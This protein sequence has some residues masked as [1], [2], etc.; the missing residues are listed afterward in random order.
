M[1]HAT[2]RDG[3]PLHYVLEGD[4]GPLVVLVQGLGLSGAFWGDVPQTLLESTPR[5]RVLRVDNRGV[6]GTGRPWRP[7]SIADMAD[8]VACVLDAVGAQT[9]YL[10]GISMGGMIAQEFALRHPGRLDGLVLMAT[11][12]GLPHGVPP[13]P[14]S[15]ALLA[16]VPFASIPEGRQRIF[17]QLFFGTHAPEESRRR[18][19]AM[20]SRWRPLLEAER[21]SPRTFLWQLSAAARHSAGRRLA[22]IRCPV[23]VVAGADDV[24][25]LP[26]NSKRLAQL[27]PHATLE[28]VEKAGHALP[29]DAPRVVRDSI[30]RVRAAR[31]TPRKAS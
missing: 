24:L 30:D 8:D 26:E 31:E 1:P 18:A 6:G 2:A 9:A 5:H 10:A 20:M 13:P 29:A 19:E 21:R 12:P 22:A 27:I 7:W 25:I 11:T 3:T 15:L 16:R 14:S 17:E 23:H 28:L 4:E